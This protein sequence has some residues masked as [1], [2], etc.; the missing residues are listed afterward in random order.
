MAEYADRLGPSLLGAIE[1]KGYTELTS[2]QR[3]VLDPALDGRDLRITSQTGSGK[4][5][6]IGL[7]LRELVAAESPATAGVARPRALVIAPT[8]ELAHQVEEELRWLFA[9]T[10]ARLATTTGGASYR[11]ERRS[12]AKGPSLVVGTPGRLVDHLAR[13]SIDPSA[14]GAVV[15]DEA[16]RMLDLGFRDDLEAIFKS[17]PEARATHLVSATF[18]SLVRSLADRVQRDPAHVQGTQ[19][20]AA[21]VDIDHVIHVIDPRQR[22]DALI[23]LL[24]AND[25]E[26]TLVFVR[27]RA[28]AAEVANELIVAGFAASALS[29]EMQQE[30]RNRTLSAYRQ[31]GLRVLVATDVAARGID[32]ADVTRVVHAELPTHPDAYTHRSGRT[33]RAGR[34]GTSSLLVA[35]AGVVHATRLLRRLGIHPR[36]EPIPSAAQIERARDE[37]LFAELT[38]QADAGVVVEGEQRWRELAE[39]LIQA[40]SLE[41]T[42]SRLLAQR[43]ANGTKA[44]ELRVVGTPPR[45]RAAGPSARE[46]PRSQP[47][48]ARASYGDEE[49][50]RRPR[51]DAGPQ[52]DLA[53]APRRPRDAENGRPEAGFREFRVSWGEQR[54][55]DPRRMLA[56]LCRRGQIRGRDVGAIRIEARHSIVGIANEVAGAFAIAAEQPDPREPGILIRPA[57]EPVRPEKSARPLPHPRR[58]AP[59]RQGGHKPLARRK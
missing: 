41:R 28:D 40:G 53:H 12:F 3:A 9:D 50:M 46:R 16:D 51:R 27:T 7:A 38:A 6:A 57:D 23:N 18:P 20:G 43:H 42:L 31:G 54:G 32:V 21:N 14:V 34:K 35:P 39:R 19:L 26:Q 10:S 48:G 47:R 44:R 37:H 36:Y 45:D 5:L 24:L 52:E 25:T 22:L 1:R 30:A 13:G 8:R 4:T 55:A 2:V 11:D 15:L 33:G 29:G 58:K 56:M 49:P 59:G 17:V